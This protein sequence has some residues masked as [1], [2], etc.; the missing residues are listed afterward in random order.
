VH[1]SRSQDS[2]EVCGM[3]CPYVLLEITVKVS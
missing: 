3:T 2:S 1:K